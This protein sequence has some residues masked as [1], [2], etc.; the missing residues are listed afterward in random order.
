[1]EME[2][3]KQKVM[4]KVMATK[5]HLEQELELEQARQHGQYGL[6][7]KINLLDSLYQNRVIKA[8]I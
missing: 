8:K 7:R 5:V 1:M 6:E 4:G 2:M 3:K